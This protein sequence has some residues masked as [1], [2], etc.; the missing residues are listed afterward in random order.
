VITSARAAKYLGAVKTAQKMP[1]RDESAVLATTSATELGAVARTLT[2]ALAPT[3]IDAVFNA[4]SVERAGRLHQNLVEQEKRSFMDEIN[5]QVQDDW[6]MAMA[7]ASRLHYPGL[8]LPMRASEQVIKNVF[9][10][11]MAKIDGPAY[12]DIRV[13]K[14]LDGQA[15]ATGA[16]P[17]LSTALGQDAARALAQ[18]AK[19]VGGVAAD[20]TKAATDEAI[21]RAIEAVRVREVAA[22]VRGQAERNMTEH[23]KLVIA[24]QIEEAAKAERDRQIAQ[25]TE[26]LLKEEMEREVQ[27]ETEQKVREETERKVREETERNVREE[28]DRIVKE[29]ALKNVERE[30]MSRLD[31]VH[32]TFQNHVADADLRERFHEFAMSNLEDRYKKLRSGP[33]KERS[34]AGAEATRTA[35]YLDKSGTPRT[36]QV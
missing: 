33:A 20:Q 29:E 9:D 18:T 12:L 26:R 3:V 15:K 25:E 24:E 4:E 1:V 36:G 14:F 28:T 17:L 7:F 21:H 19:V 23:A 34:A 8:K 22:A 5:E 35:E 6:L 16:A 11:V 32:A 2:A 31:A 10:A 13:G 27:R 30:L